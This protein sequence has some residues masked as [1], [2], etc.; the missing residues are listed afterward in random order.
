MRKEGREDGR[1]EDGRG[2]EG[3]GRK[4]GGR[5]GGLWIVGPLTTLGGVVVIHLWELSICGWSRSFVRHVGS[6]TGW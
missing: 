6:L 3:R 5:V 2:E 1:G 4:K